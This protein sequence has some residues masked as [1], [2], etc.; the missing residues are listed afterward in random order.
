MATDPTYQ[1]MTNTG[2]GPIAVP[3]REV[4]GKLRRGWTKMDPPGTVSAKPRAAKPRA[5]KE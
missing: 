2:T 5:A 1:W 4:E 3:L